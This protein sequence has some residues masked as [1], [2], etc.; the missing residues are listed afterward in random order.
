MC[1]S[2]F[3]RLPDAHLFSDCLHIK[4]SYVSIMLLVS[5]PSPQ[6]LSPLGICRPVNGWGSEK[7]ELSDCK[8]S[9]RWQQG[10]TSQHPNPHRDKI[11]IKKKYLV[12]FPISW[13]LVASPFLST[14]STSQGLTIDL[15]PATLQVNKFWRC[16]FGSS[17]PILI[18]AELCNFLWSSGA[19]KMIPQVKASEIKTKFLCDLPIHL[20]FLFLA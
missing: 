20:S 5:P 7:N 9:V 8:P 10:V 15:P 13:F 12:F 14:A 19:W 4:N 11:L 3:H 16:H 6:P 2:H 17:P 18:L 1:V